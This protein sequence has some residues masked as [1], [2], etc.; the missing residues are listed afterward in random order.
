MEL[1]NIRGRD[2][3]LILGELLLI[4]EVSWAVALFY[5]IA[6]VFLSPFLSGFHK[7]M[8]SGPGWFIDHMYCFP[9]QFY[10]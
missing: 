6:T 3:G 9:W 4:L 8:V 5:G 10:S 1:C 2:I 7:I